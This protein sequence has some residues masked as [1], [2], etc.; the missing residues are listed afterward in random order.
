METAN[1]NVAKD[2]ADLQENRMVSFVGVSLELQHNLR[3]KLPRRVRA[4]KEGVRLSS[5]QTSHDSGY[6][7]P[8]D[9][10]TYFLKALRI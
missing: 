9:P 8:F 7:P 4:K 2:I 3:A 1:K 10:V 5:H 6:S